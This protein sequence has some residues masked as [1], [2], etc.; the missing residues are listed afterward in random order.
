MLASSVVSGSG[1]TTVELSE[2]DSDVSMGI[3]TDRQPRQAALP[4]KPLQECL[5]ELTAGASA[6]PS[7]PSH[8]TLDMVVAAGIKS[9]PIPWSPLNPPP[10]TE[11]HPLECDA[12]DKPDAYMRDDYYIDSCA[13]T[14]KCIC[15]FIR[16][17]GGHDPLIVVDQKIIDEAT[18][19][20]AG[21][22]FR[23]SQ[24]EFQGLMSGDNL[25]VGQVEAKVM[26]LYAAAQLLER[27]QMY[28]AWPTT[29]RAPLPAGGCL[30][31]RSADGGGVRCCIPPQT[32]HTCCC[33]HAANG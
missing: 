9:S 7:S 26:Y 1:T 21:A 5:D 19:H 24:T 17:E 20:I 25:L 14:A 33:T 10:P 6:E 16:K 32:P 27:Q 13:E 3:H 23:L 12:G 11:P 4:L 30:H 8:V 15:D 18:R 22:K 31:R 2:S 29:W 28:Q